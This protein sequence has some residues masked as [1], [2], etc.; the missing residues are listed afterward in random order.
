[1]SENMLAEVRWGVA[2]R[3]LSQLLPFIPDG[4]PGI[5][6]LNHSYKPGQ[7]NS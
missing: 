2:C 7:A 5:I 4:A 6:L 3:S 1:M